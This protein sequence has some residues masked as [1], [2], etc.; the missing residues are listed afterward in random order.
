M[1]LY[2][3]VIARDYGFAPNPFHG[4]CTLATCKPVIRRVAARGDW[5][6][7]TG[8]KVRYQL[9]GHLIYAMKVDEAL[10]FDEYWSDSR[11]QAKK[12]DLMGSLKVAYGDNIYHRDDGDWVQ[13]DS[14]HTLADGSTNVHN[15]ERDTQTD[16]VLVSKRFVYWGR[17]APRIPDRFRSF[18]PEDVDICSSGRGHLTHDGSLAAAFVAWLEKVDTW[19]VR[20]EPL[21]FE[22]HEPP[23]E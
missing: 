12:P 1:K 3:Y 8:A 21:E 7:G 22:R 23:T 9:Q 13:L 20:D 18:G 10:T 19:G 15:V 4:F 2:S 5:I 14:H 16:R 6:V 17:S 11:F